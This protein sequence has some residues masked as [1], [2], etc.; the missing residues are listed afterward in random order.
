MKKTLIATVLLWCFLWGGSPLPAR[1]ADEQAQVQMLMQLF[2]LT[3]PEWLG[4]LNENRML[5]DASF[6]ERCDSRIRWAIENNQIDDALRMSI[7]ADMAMKSNGQVGRYRM[8]M[9]YAFLKAN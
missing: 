9:V 8:T 4:L 6:F 1:A 2:R 5:L 3:Q 7:V